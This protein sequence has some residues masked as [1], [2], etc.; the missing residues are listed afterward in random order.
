LDRQKGHKAPYFNFL[1][2]IVYPEQSEGSPNS[3]KGQKTLSNRPYFGRPEH[4]EGSPIKSKGL[5]DPPSNFP[6]KRLKIFRE[7]LEE[8]I[9]LLN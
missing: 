4:S 6:Q 3:G 9:A 8:G 2:K 7:E 5:K 1:E